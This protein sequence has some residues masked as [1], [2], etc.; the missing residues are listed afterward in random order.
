[1]DGFTCSLCEQEFPAASTFHGCRICD[2]D[3][4][5]SCFTKQVMSSGKGAKGMESGKSGKGAC[6]MDSIESSFKG[7]GVGKGGNFEESSGKGNKGGMEVQF[8]EGQ[9]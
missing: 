6:G 4:C 3:E 7:K 1:M 8:M 2:Y 9:Q 5:I